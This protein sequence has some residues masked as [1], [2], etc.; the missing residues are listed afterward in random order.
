MD[1]GQSVRRTRWPWDQ[2]NAAARTWRAGEYGPDGQGR[3]R[4]LPELLQPSAGA[5]A[6]SGRLPLDLQDDR[7]D[8]RAAGS[9]LANKTLEIGADFFLDDSV[10]G[11]LFRSGAMQGTRQ[12]GMQP[13]LPIFAM[14]RNQVTRLHQVHNQLQFFLAGMA[15][16]MYGRRRSIFVNHIGLPPEEVVNHAVDGLLIS[17]ND[18]R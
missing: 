12:V 9:G 4:L 7:H 16:H 13:E 11:F 8:Q 18:A 3:F 14:D 15:A 2:R 17:G 5:C 6:A 1:A 10:I